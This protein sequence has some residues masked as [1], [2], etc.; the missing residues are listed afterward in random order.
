MAIQASVNLIKWLGNSKYFILC[1]ESPQTHLPP[2]HSPLGLPCPL[3]SLHCGLVRT[4]IALTLTLSVWC[5]CLCCHIMNLAEARA[6]FEEARARAGKEFSIVA[7][8]LR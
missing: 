1:S 8:G 4:I 6:L 2:S 3:T 7:E 5:V